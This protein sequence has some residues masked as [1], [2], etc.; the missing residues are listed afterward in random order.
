MGALTAYAIEVAIILAIMYIVYKCLLANATFYRFNR[1]VLKSCYLMALVVPIIKY[2]LIFFNV[3][4]G[5][6]DI[7]IEPVPRSYIWEIQA[8]TYKPFNIFEIIPII[9]F[10]GVIV[11]TIFTL[12][13]Y[14]KLFIL[15]HRGE[16]RE[17]AGATIVIAD[18]KVSPFSWGR[19]L[20]VSEADADNELIVKHELI[21]IKYRHSRDL[22]YGQLFIIFNWFNPAAYLMRRELSA[23]HEYEVD[24]E[25]L[26]LGVEATDYQML[27]IRK[28]AGPVFQSIANSLNHSQLKN[29]LT[30][31]MKSKSKRVRYLCA[32]ALLPAAIVAVALTD[33]PAVA[34]TINNVSEV[35]FD[36]VSKKYENEQTLERGENWQSTTDSQA[37][38]AEKDEPG[39]VYNSAEVFPQYPGSDKAMMD[40]IIAEVKYPDINI[41]EEDK[42]KSAYVVVQ[43]TVTTD[44]TMSDFFIRR[45][46]GYAEADAEAVR[47]IQAALT[48]KWSPGKI[49]GEPVNVRFT[50]PVKFT[51]KK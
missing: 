41:K 29:R 12:Y 5:H 17:T 36:K 37:P 9:Y 39:K 3:D 31:M 50:L 7:E 32:A 30:M 46:S 24:R 28:A 19:Y 47:A 35:T 21:H 10:A 27:L 14:I 40:A 44:G 18:T 34:S 2:A 49:N 22:F 11:M 51:F 1:G 6:T 4:S 20:I 38:V 26:K 33:I 15:I 42:E 16:K 43:F 8:E 25:I 48:E 45:S 23:V 13:S